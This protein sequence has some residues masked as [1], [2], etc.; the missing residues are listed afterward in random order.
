MATVQKLKADK[1]MLI[2][3]AGEWGSIHHRPHHFAL[4]AERSGWNVLY[5]EPP[6]SLLALFKNKELAKRRWSRIGVRHREDSGIGVRP[7]DNLHILAPPPTLPFGNRFRWVNRLN[8]RIIA[9]SI[10][11]ALSTIDQ[12][13]D[14]P[15]DLYSYL[16]SAVDL[17]PLLNF[18][19]IIYDCVDDH[20]AFTGTHS[21]KTLDTMER[22]LMQKA[23]VSFATA[24]QLMKDR[25]GWSGNF[26]LIPNGAE[27]EHF[28]PAVNKLYPL[29]QDI[30]DLAPPIIGFVGG[31][32]DWINIELI[33]ETAALLPDYQFVLIGPIDTDV[34]ILKQQ[35][36]ITLLGPK[37]YDNL[38]QYLSHFDVCLIP[39]RINKLTASVNP[40]KMYEYL[41]AGKPIAA[42]PM[43]EVIRFESVIRIAATA[44]E[45]ADTITELLQL[46]NS[47]ASVAAVAERQQLALE[48]SWDARWQAVL[49][50]LSHLS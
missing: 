27:Y 29:P 42:T 11:R 43:P 30:S 46:A 34:T 9:R 3:S 36:N 16:P 37:H 1:T 7:R 38:P 13:P 2:I 39:F 32:S 21:K 12:P 47:E 17:L 22:E 33:A 45:T 5:V 26:H 15:I 35:P 18:A 4:R 10:K 23:D 8:Q 6:A 20:A 28:A 44:Q 40:I 14:Q 41:A 24:T 19:N 48:N 50:R 25:S 49:S 31:I